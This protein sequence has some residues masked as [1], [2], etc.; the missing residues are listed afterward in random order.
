MLAT[1]GMAMAAGND[2]IT[3][4]A[5]LPQS[6]SVNISSTLIELNLTSTAKTQGFTYRCNFGSETSNASLVF[7]SGSN[8]VVGPGG[9]LDYS[10]TVGTATGNSNA[11]LTVTAPVATANTDIDASFSVA[12]IEFPTIAGTYSDI[13][14]VSITP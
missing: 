13:L 7:D 11:P 14:T 8:A 4:S 10:I 2:T 3:V 9:E 1:T 6:C 12:L 5:I